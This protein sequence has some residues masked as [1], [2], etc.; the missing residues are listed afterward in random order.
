MK[1]WKERLEAIAMA[2]AYAEAGDWDEARNL[3]KKGQR[4]SKPARKDRDKRSDRRPRVNIY[5][6]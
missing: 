4:P 2:I 5:H 1:K 3:A 6:S